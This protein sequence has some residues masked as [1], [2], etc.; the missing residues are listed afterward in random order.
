MQKSGLHEARAK[1]FFFFLLIRPIVVFHRS[2]ALPS[3]LS[4]TQS[5]FYILFEQTTGGPDVVCVNILIF[6]W[7]K[8][9][10]SSKLP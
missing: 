10:E 1:S 5:R 9:D 7:I 4:I 3:P 6:T 2:P 8:W